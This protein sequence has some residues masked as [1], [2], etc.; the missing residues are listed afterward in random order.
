MKLSSYFSKNKVQ[1]QLMVIIT[2]TLVIGLGIIS[3][4]SIKGN[5]RDMKRI[6]EGKIDFLSSAI[7]K[8]VKVVMVS[9]NAEIVRDWLTE[10][11]NTPGLKKIGIFRKNGVEAFIDNE[12]VNDV[13]KYLGSE[14]FPRKAVSESPKKFEEENIQKLKKLIDSKIEVSYE[15]EMNGEPVNT[16]L[17]PIIKDERCEACHD[18]DKNPVRGILQI[19]ISK[20]ELVNSIRS[21]IQW[22]VVSVFVVIVLVGIIMNFL[23]NREII[24]PLTRA[25]FKISNAADNQDKITSQ[26][27]AAVNQITAAIEELNVSSKQISTR[28]E[29]LSGQ[30]NEALSVAY[31]GQKAV[32]NSISEMN[33]IKKKVTDIAENV[34]TLSEKTNQIG[35]II[36]VVE[37]IANKTDMLA[38]NA[39]IEAAKA[40]EHGR[41]FAVVASEVRSL[42]DQS[43]KATEKITSLIHDIQDSVNTTVMTTEEG[44]KKVDAGV[45]HVMEAGS[46]INN[47]INTIKST[48][49]AANEIA[50][51]SRQESSA[52]EQVEQAM[53]QINRGMHESS[54]ATKDYIVIIQQLQKLVD[55]RKMK[56]EIQKE[57]EEFM[58]E[59]MDS[60]SDV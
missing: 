29:S 13:N 10:V 23:I 28:A 33:L 47:A 44:G 14:T 43:K 58:N 60:E 57:E 36:N 26:Q 21:S 6:E 41:G 9:G 53:V 49:D 40:G 19:S 59:D 3:V 54:T 51:A 30:A 46:T 8:G 5:I 31:E 18:Y 37:D 2:L 25:I 35:A 17:I 4:F 11:R 42:S 24:K 22:A 34:L 56:R 52:T 20:R 55:R 45:S 50:I 27:A 1:R 16:R 39:A 7:S 15:E 48:A 32:E 38:V 12:T